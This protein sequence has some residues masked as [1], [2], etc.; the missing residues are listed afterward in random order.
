MVKKRGLALLLLLL[1][2]IS[3]IS[4]CSPAEKNYYSL[5]SEARTRP[6]FMD[7]GSY[8]I[9]VSA[10]PAGMF[11]G[12]ESLD[13]QTL[14]SS[15]G[16]LQIQYRGQVDKRQQV[17]Q[18]D[19]TVWDSRSRTQAG[20]FSVLYKDG[21]MYLRI[22]QMMDFIKGLCAPAQRENL[23]RIF[24]GVEWVSWSEQDMNK[25]AP[26]SRESLTPQLLLNS[27]GQQLLYKRILDSLIND[28][29]DEYSSG[30]VTRS[31]NKYTMALRGSDLMT[32][33][34]SGAV[35]T[36]KNA[37]RLS[38]AVESFL[39]GLTPAEAAQMGLTEATRLQALQSLHEAV[40]Q[41]ERDGPNLIMELEGMGAT[42]D[43]Q[44]LRMIN[45]SEIISSIEETGSNT[46]RIDSRVRLNI[47]DPVNPRDRL[48]ATIVTEQAINAG[49]PVQVAVPAGA[50]PLAEL[51]GWSPA[52]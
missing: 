25:V 22:D 40:A 17:F 52:R 32:V 13:A 19:Y 23:E 14:I 29:Y 8:T 26:G 38:Q 9:A 10:L 2:G 12:Q 44:L 27:S 20:A 47:G 45:D 30:L 7:S 34:K 37:A 18:Y 39:E 50:V 11:T 48:S 6:V 49:G 24:A 15:L 51:P 31:G 35:Y 3:L 21:V 16:Q 42:P 4:G 43:S 5:M 33:F 46:Y 41:V 1:M 28:V 36:V